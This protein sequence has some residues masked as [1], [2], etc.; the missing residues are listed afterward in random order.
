MSEYTPSTED[1]TGTIIAAL[2]GYYGYT[3]DEARTVLA[4][5]D[6]GVLRR[7]WSEGAAAVGGHHLVKCPYP[8]A[9]LRGEG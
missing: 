1:A 6:A 2:R 3:A 9:E 4:E 8:A 5:H 7:G